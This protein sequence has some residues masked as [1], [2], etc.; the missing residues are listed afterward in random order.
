MTKQKVIFDPIHGNILVKDEFLKI[1]DHPVFQRLHYISQ[2]GPAFYVYPGATHT[3]FSHSLGVFHIMSKLLSSIKNQRTWCSNHKSPL[4]MNKLFS[5]DRISLLKVSALLHDIGHFPFSHTLEDAIGVKHETVSALIIREVLHE[6]IK[7]LNI[8]PND[9]ANLIAGGPT[10]TYYKL[11]ISSTIDADR[12]DYLLRDAYFTGVGYGNLELERLLSTISV[13][14]DGESYIFPEKSLHAVENYI[15]GRYYMYQTTYN[16]SVVNSFEA[17]LS[18]IT[19]HLISESYI[20]SWNELKGNLSNNL[21]FSFDDSY[22]ISAMRKYLQDG[23]NK[24]IKNVIEAYFKRHPFKK[25]YEIS[26]MMENTE[27]SLEKS[28]E[29][30]TFL[31]IKENQDLLNEL[32]DKSG[33]PTEYFALISVENR[34]FKSDR[35]D[36]KFCLKGSNSPIPILEVPRSIFYLLRSEKNRMTETL[37]RLY[38]KT[39]K[40]DGVPYAERIKK[41]LHKEFNINIE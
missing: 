5:K 2:L 37:W 28:Y 7:K 35:M 17:M 14:H 34:I 18:K 39:G 29:I 8:T 4:D 21:W 25:I 15:L 9:V 3:R 12:L 23:S 32:A 41:V 26:S 16:H 27:K 20:P 31:E 24:N 19:R 30:K 11:L 36:I 10:I 33:V 40:I 13:S 1:V 22:V 38:V 6:E